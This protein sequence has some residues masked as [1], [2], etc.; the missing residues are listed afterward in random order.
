M[1]KTSTSSQ[2]IKTNN[3]TIT[4]SKHDKENPYVMILREI[5]EDKEISPKAKGVLGYLLSRPDHWTFYHHQLQEALNVGETYL[6][7]AI[8]ELI[9]AGYARRS[10]ARDKG[11][12]DNYH[13]EISEKKRFKSPDGIFRPG[14]SGPENQ[15]LSNN[16]IVNTDL[17][18]NE[19]ESNHH[20]DSPENVGSQKK[21]S[22]PTQHNIDYSTQESKIDDDLIF[23]EKEK[24]RLIKF[25]KE[26]IEEAKSRTKSH[27]VQPANHLRVKF[28]F[29][30]LERL[31]KYP[32]KKKLSVFDELC[33]Y[34][35]PKKEYNGAEC[36]LNSEWI[37]FHRGNHQEQ[38]RINQYWSW[39]KF[40]EMCGN[41]QIKFSRA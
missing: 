4:R 15:D 30:T 32:P 1:A 31:H 29:T 23:S 12:F 40:T 3:S 6:N 2:D 33:Q 38:L 17:V 21:F 19:Y 28:F 37:A 26:L 34:F 25:P 20:Q 16:D 18:S 27:C 7:S 5:F 9:N 41:F 10:R 36:I 13:Y 24:Q 14:F 35:S 8:E 39:E 11:K 22:Q